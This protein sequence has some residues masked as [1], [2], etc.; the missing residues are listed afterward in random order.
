VLFE[1]RDVEGLAT[2]LDRLLGDARLRE[3]FG[4][5]AREVARAR[6]DLEDSVLRYRAL[7]RA[8]SRRRGASPT[9]RAPRAGAAL[10]R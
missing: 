7:F 6:F 2:A 9:A 3:R 10:P 5:R 1:P 8:V 4:T